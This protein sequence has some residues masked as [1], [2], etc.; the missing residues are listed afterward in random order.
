MSRMPQLLSVNRVHALLPD[1]ARGLRTAID[2]RPVQG[3][4][5]VGRLGLAGDR[6][7]DTAFHGGPDKAVY[8]YAVEDAERWGAE[9]GREIPPGLFGENLTLRGLDITH[10]VIG[11]RWQLGTDPDHVVVEVTMPRIPCS[12]FQ[13][14]MGE[15]GWVRRF[16]EGG[17]P[18][19]YLRV[20]RE[21][22][23]QAGDAVCVVH[24][25]SHGATVLDAFDRDAPEAMRAVLA[26]A[27]AGDLV[28][29]D[30]L[31]L[32]AER[33]AGCRHETLPH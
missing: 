2:K 3:P 16:T 18:G 4:V 17:A 10:A 6:Q 22:T 14:R 11:E 19:A 20:V 28:L 27:D 12:T 31:R 30:A 29:A 8:A 25:P 15:P 9:L 21:G 23:V 7:M 5:S 26:A 33:V 1:G 24:R 32:H 13:R